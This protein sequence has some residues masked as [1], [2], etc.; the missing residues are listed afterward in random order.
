MGIKLSYLLND[1]RGNFVFQGSQTVIFQLAVTRDFI[2]VK[3]NNSINA[4][5]T[6]R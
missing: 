4:Y 5:V 6:L 1:N 2:D 3:N